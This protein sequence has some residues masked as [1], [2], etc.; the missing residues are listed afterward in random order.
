MN[1]IRDLGN[2]QTIKIIGKTYKT[3][4]PQNIDKNRTRIP[5]KNFINFLPFSR[6]KQ[7]RGAKKYEKI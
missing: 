7:I 1:K 2:K 4:P 3:L 5:S 6:K